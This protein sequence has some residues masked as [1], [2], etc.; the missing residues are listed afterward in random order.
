MTAPVVAVPVKPFGVAKRRLAS[1]LDLDQRRGL[2]QAL[3]VRVTSMAARAGALPLVLSADHE[4]TAW[5]RGNG[6]DVLLDEG[7]SLDRAA[8]SAA[9]WAA[10]R[11]RAW[12]VCHAD[13][14]LLTAL[15]LAPALAAADAGRPV[16]APS[17]DGG[18]SLLGWIDP[19]FEFRYG[20]GSFHRHLASIAAHRPTIIV[21]VGLALDLDRPSDLAAAAGHPR[22]AWLAAVSGAGER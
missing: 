4:V 18:T 1:V 10:D 2:S 16:I 7:S 6:I 14:P 19:G 22:G 17:S 9:R 20:P 21:S 8:S 11:G 12:I 3:A 15:D 5:A 13:L